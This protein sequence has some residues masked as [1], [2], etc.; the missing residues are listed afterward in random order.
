MKLRQLL[1]AYY[2]ELDKAF[3]LY[4]MEGLFDYGEETA[5]R[6]R[7][8]LKRQFA[9]F[10]LLHGLDQTFS[11]EKAIGTFTALYKKAGKVRNKQ[12]ESQLLL[13]IE[14]QLHLVFELSGHLGAKAD[15]QGK[16]LQEWER[17][18]SPE[19]IKELAKQ[20]LRYIHQLP[21]D[22]IE[23][24]MRSYFVNLIRA[25][26]GFPNSPEEADEALHDLRKFIKELFYNLEI[27]KRMMPD[28]M[29]HAHALT[30]LDDFQHLLGD[31]HDRDFS[32][33]HLKRIK[34]SV[35]KELLARLIAEKEAM[36]GTIR[37]RLPMLAPSLLPL[38]RQLE[39][40]L[41]V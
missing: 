19:T 2:Q 10:H 17:S 26:G 41:T 29:L 31:W 32:I 40:L 27:I 39:E 14:R 15:W 21:E 25:I 30:Q 13:N 37:K 33:H 34:T 28:K 36:E 1:S 11:A 6:I 18:H 3:H 24:R 38:E 12:V 4:W 5:H 9:F 35:N 20:V 16:I 8:N 23:H 22:G 7:V